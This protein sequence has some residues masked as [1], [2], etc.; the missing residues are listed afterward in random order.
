M[1]GLGQAGAANGRGGWYDFGRMRFP[2]TFMGVVSIAVGVF[3]VSYLLAH[4]TLDPVAT[5][6]AVAAAVL[7]FVF[8]GYVLVRRV[9]RGREA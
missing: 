6:V 8:G 5:G 7:A 4:R 1:S 9:Q 3:V 2:F